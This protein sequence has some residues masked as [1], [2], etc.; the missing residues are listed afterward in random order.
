MALLPELEAF[1]D[2]AT[3]QFNLLSLDISRAHACSGMQHETSVPV[4]FCC[5]M[6][7]Y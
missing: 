3:F 5:A 6:R 2:E 4:Q 1:P 7:D